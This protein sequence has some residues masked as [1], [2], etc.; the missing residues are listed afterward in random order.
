MPEMYPLLD[1]SKSGHSGGS[2]AQMFHLASAL[3]KKGHVVSVVVGDYGQPKSHTIAGIEAFRIKNRRGLKPWRIFRTIIN[4]FLLLIKCKPDVVMHQ[5]Y[6]YF[7]GVS[8]IFCRV[9]GIPYVYFTASQGDVD[10]TRYRSSSR[11][12]A[13][14]WRLGLKMTS[15]IIVQGNDHR[16]LLLKHFYRDSIVVPNGI[17]TKQFSRTRE[18][19]NTILWVA[20]WRQVKRPDIVA[21]LAQ[22]L[23]NCTFIMCGGF[24]DKDLYQ[25]IVSTFP[26]NIIIRGHANASELLNAYQDAI[27][28]INTSDYEGIPITFD[29][30]WSCELP[31]VSLNVDPDGVI[32]RHS[33]GFVSKT[34]DQMVKD[35]KFLCE[36]KRKTAE[37]G[38]GCR[39][40]V[41]KNHNIDIMVERINTILFLQ[42][43]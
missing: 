26:Q 33:L 29:E 24:Y 21:E 35:I 31:V 22:R 37:L 23:P 41:V 14:L 8:A 40:F 17:D 27:L 30:A 18:H 13:W 9:L 2:E 1:Q 28:L 11:P 5:N 38:L 12:V 10:G 43:S 3:A 32:T 15:T 16:E 25:R 6:G 7:H 4:L 36:D 34:I 19:G 39:D 42:C 20:H